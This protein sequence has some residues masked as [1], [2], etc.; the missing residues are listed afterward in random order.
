LKGRLTEQRVLAVEQ[1]RPWAEE[2]GRTTGELAIAWLLAHQ[3]V[4]C[5]IVGARNPE[6]IEQNLR[7]ANWRLTP[8]ERDEVATIAGK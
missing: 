8:E 4:S 3:E 1:L 6:Q 7:A 5:V 2:R